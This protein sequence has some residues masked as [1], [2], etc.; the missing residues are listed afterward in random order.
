MSQQSLLPTDAVFSVSEYLDLL[1]GFLQ[2]VTVTVR[3]EVTRVQER[4]SAVYFTLADQQQKASLDGLIWRDKL[5][6]SG[7]DLKVGEEYACIG[8]ANIYKPTGRLSFLTDRLTP[9]GEG[10]LQAAFEKLKRELEKEGY[11]AVGR[12]RELPAYIENIV[13]ISSAQGDAIRDFRTHI[14]TYGQQIELIDARVEGVR[15]IDSIVAAFRSINAQP[16]TAQ[17]IVLTRGGGSLESLQA[18]NSREVAEAIYSSKIPVVSAVG[19]ER[20]ITIA[21]LVADLRASTPTDAGKILSRDW[22][23]ATDRLREI[24]QLCVWSM[25]KRVASEKNRLNTWWKI[26]T[27]TYHHRLQVLLTTLQ[28]STQLAQPLFQRFQQKVQQAEWQY[29]GW[30]DT[31]MSVWRDESV[32]VQAFATSLR[33]RFRFRLLQLAQEV[34]THEKVFEAVSPHKRLQQGY[35][36]MKSSGGEIVRSTSQTKKGETL[37]ITLQDGMMQTQIIEIQKGET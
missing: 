32:T 11:F 6:R 15:A 37:H 5:W 3:G 22:S 17:V 13:V 23:T 9:L 25:E 20:D 36:W 16:S 21:D 8:A 12:K 4:G 10:A 27:E 19:H 30:K 26:W 7:V 28:T 34:S 2:P 1:N 24:Q 33:E 18:F 35:V 29:S 14:G 31:W